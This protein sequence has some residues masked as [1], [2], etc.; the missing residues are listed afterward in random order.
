MILP[1]FYVFFLI[2]NTVVIRDF[3]FMRGLKLFVFYFD[4]FLR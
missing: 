4:Y 3:T 2:N 1:N